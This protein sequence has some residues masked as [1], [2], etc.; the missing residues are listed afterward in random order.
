[1]FTFIER[2]AY[3][4]GC[5]GVAT[6]K[7]AEL[8]K[9]EPSG[10][11]PHTLILIMGDTVNAIVAFDE[12]IDKTIKRITLIDT[13]QDEKFEALRVAEKMGAKLFGIRL[14]TPG[15]RRG[16]FL[17]ILE[18]ILVGNWICAASKT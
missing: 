2:N 5:D 17:A 14:D 18:E 11:I 7:S 3:I 10:T 6:I 13:F 12:I 9:I 4:G 1:M 8:L 16:D 15:S